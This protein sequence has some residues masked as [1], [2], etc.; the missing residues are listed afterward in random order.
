M[1][2]NSSAN[3]CDLFL[4]QLKIKGPKY[5]IAKF[6]LTITNLG[7]S[8]RTDIINI[9]LLL[10]DI[11]YYCYYYYYCYCCRFTSLSQVTGNRPHCKWKKETELRDKENVP[12]QD[13]SNT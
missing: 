13:Y 12:R 10:S 5:K 7:P 3:D 4:L 11:F 2:R 6:W 9:L 8:D 1:R